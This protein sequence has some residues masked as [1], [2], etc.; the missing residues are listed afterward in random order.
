MIELLSP[1]GNFNKL[2]TAFRYGADACYIDTAHGIT[3]A[4]RVGFNKFCEENGYGY[5]Y[6]SMAEF[7]TNL[8]RAIVFNVFNKFQQ[9]AITN[10][11]KN[12]KLNHH[13]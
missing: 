8:K 6:S 11:V 1:A 7:K 10:T 4:A 5:N 12:I 2:V 9:S 3:E 13:L